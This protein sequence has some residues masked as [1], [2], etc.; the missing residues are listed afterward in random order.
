V[1]LA[2][3]VRP[4]DDRGLGLVADGRQDRVERLA[5]LVVGLGLVR[6]LVVEGRLE[7]EAHG[8]PEIL[9]ALFLGEEPEDARQAHG[10]RGR[11][12]E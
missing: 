3:A 9:D 10:R 2:V 7:G 1:R 4:D 11:G 6:G 8:A 12:G 5:D